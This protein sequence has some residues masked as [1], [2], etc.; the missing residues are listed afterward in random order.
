VWCIEPGPLVITLSDA[1]PD[2][3]EQGEN[4]SRIAFDV[5]A[6]EAR[7]SS[8]PPSG[9]ATMFARPSTTRSAAGST[10]AQLGSACAL[11]GGADRVTVFVV[12]KI[13]TRP[14]GEDVTRFLDSVPDERRRAEGHE[15]RALFERVTGVPAVMWGPSMVGFGSRPYTNTTGINDWFVVGFSPR[16]AA[17]TIYGIFDGYASAPDPMITELGPV[18]TG[19]S[20]V[21]VKRLDRIDRDV[22][23]QLVSKAWSSSTEAT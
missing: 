21:Y 1:A 16:K 23:T 4:R 18:T 10:T 6:V 20:C 22:L 2:V 5:E 12:A 19:K 7:P 14:T 11:H 17:L 15:L 8:S 13:K 3:F 9:R